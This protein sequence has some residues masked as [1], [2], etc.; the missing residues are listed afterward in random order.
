MI[1]ISAAVLSFLAS[2]QHWYSPGGLLADARRIAPEIF[3]EIVFA[4]AAIA[5]Y[6]GGELV[7]KERRKISAGGTD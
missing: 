3:A 4:V 7:Y 6:R 5:I 1:G 2:P